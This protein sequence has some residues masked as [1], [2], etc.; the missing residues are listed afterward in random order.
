[1]SDPSSS[2]SVTAPSATASDVRQAIH[3]FEVEFPIFEEATQAATRVLG[4]PICAVGVPHNDLLVLKAATGLSQ[5]GLM[6]PL[7]RHRRLPLNDELVRHVLQEKQGLILPTISEHEPF[8]Q[9]FLVQQY[10]IM[11]FVGVPLLTTD[12]T[13]MGLLAAMDV[14]SHDFS[15]VEIAYLELLARWSISEYERH[16]LTLGQVVSERTKI[17]D[18]GS[19]SALAIQTSV[20][21]TVRLTLMNQLTREMRNPLTTISGMSSML[22]REIYGSLTVKQREYTSIVYDSSRAMLEMANEILDLSELGIDLQQLT[23][24]SVDFE[25]LAQCVQKKLTPLAQENH[26]EIRLTVEPESRL[27]KLD[28]DLMRQLLYY[29]V[30]SV[31]KFSREG[32]TV[33][34]HGST[35]EDCLSIV[36]WVSHPWLGDGLP[37]S[38][39]P[40]RRFLSPAQVDETFLD[41]LLVRCSQSAHQKSASQDQAVEMSPEETLLQL[42]ETL[43]LLLSRY[44]IEHHRG[45][46]LFQGSSEQGYRLLVRLPELT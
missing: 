38:M 40:L 26:Q 39:L 22:S 35:R 43:A 12:G 31:I 6:N 13:C 36:I 14:V 34:I 28:K 23:A 42:R 4:I 32:G 27:W 41:Q 33:R 5:L 11:A 46:L 21:D 37:T 17:P 19:T 10:G 2:S 24:T 9:S 25:M 45:Q 30:F 1:M 20:L 15:E 29:L 7:A 18:S 44:L 3:S 16:L 8:S